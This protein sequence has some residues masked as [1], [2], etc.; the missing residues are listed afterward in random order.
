M[1]LCWHIKFSYVKAHIFVRNEPSVT[2]F[3]SPLTLQVLPFLSSGITDLSVTVFVHIWS[4]TVYTSL[5]ELPFQQPA[6]MYRV[7]RAIIHTTII[8][9]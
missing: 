4:A 9:L 8:H 1:N 2:G 3:P 5:Q 7:F 6:Y